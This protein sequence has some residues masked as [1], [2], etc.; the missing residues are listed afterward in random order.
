MSHH[1]PGE[2][3]ATA[4]SPSTSTAP[5]PPNSPTSVLSPAPT[6]FQPRPQACV[7]QRSSRQLRPPPPHHALTE[8]EQEFI[9]KNKDELYDLLLVGTCT[10]FTKTVIHIKSVFQPVAVEIPSHTY[11]LTHSYTCTHRN[12]T[13]ITHSRAQNLCT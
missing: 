13:S 10:P 3:V 5:H 1:Q 7:P 12:Y 8:W 4:A 6:P 9:S 2:G 11:T